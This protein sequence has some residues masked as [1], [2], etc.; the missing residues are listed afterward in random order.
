MAR[1]TLSMLAD[2]FNRSSLS[3]FHDRI[4]DKR[5]E[6]SVLFDQIHLTRANHHRTMYERSTESFFISLV[7]LAVQ[8]WLNSVP[9]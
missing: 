7:L 8:R 9:V 3:R 5:Q 1:S 6:Q 2:H 4:K